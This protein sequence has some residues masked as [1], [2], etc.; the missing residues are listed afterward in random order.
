MCLGLFSFPESER[1]LRLGLSSDSYSTRC[2]HSVGL[3]ENPVTASNT[4][5]VDYPPTF[6]SELRSNER[7]ARKPKASVSEANRFTK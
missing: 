2:Q 7:E 1:W 6:P 3:Q 4:A 5:T